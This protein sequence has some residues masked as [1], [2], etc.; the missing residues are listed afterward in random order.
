MPESGGE[1]KPILLPE[2]SIPTCSATPGV[3]V[4]GDVSAVLE[5]NPRGCN[6]AIQLSGEICYGHPIASCSFTLMGS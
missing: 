3:F 6:L 2:S 5:R 4:A 1:P